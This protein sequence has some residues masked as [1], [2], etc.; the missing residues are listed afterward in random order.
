[1]GGLQRWR[2]AHG[3]ECLVC[4]GQTVSID[5]RQDPEVRM[6]NYSAT[7]RKGIRRNLRAGATTVR[8]ADFSMLEH[9]YRFYVATMERNRAS[10]YYYFPLSYFERLVSH[11]PGVVHLF[12]TSFG[13]DVACAALISEYAGQLQ[14]LFIMGNPDF[15]DKAPSRTMIHDVCQWGT[16]RGAVDFHLGG[17][18]GGVEDSLFRFKAQFSDVHRDFYT[19]RAVTDQKTYAELSQLRTS[20]SPVAEEDSFFPLWRKPVIPA[21]PPAAFVS[22]NAG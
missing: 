21:A 16:E 6:A 1:V 4:H 10:D 17:G 15:E 19:F 5:L 9:F 13:A 7:L 20:V 14:A 12:V 11:A 8:D 3:G 22:A 2:P 18:R